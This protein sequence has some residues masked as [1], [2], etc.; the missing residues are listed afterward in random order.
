MTK[1]SDNAGSL[2]MAKSFL[3]AV[4]GAFGWLYTHSIFQFLIFSGGNGGGH[5]YGLMTAIPGF[6]L[7]FFWSWLI[8]NILSPN[9]LGTRISSRH[10]A[11]TAVSIIFGGVLRHA[12]APISEPGLNNASGRALTQVFSLLGL[13]LL[14]EGRSGIGSYSVCTFIAFLTC[15][16]IGLWRGV[17]VE[18]KGANVH[19]VNG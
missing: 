6:A 3:L 13:G 15:T 9:F 1:G 4:A 18:A 8:T 16:L 10:L 17:R 7:L 5:D 2:G 12:L 11:V 19:A 14:P